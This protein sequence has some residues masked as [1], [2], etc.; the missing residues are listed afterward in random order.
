MQMLDLT[1]NRLRHLEPKLVQLTG[2]LHPG[3]QVLI[4]R[5]RRLESL[6][7]V[8][9]ISHRL[10]CRLEVAVAAPKSAVRLHCGPAH[11][12]CSR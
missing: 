7:E 8:S 3:I 5:W 11:G 12:K 6:T 2:E 10:G 1:G 4:L 9:K